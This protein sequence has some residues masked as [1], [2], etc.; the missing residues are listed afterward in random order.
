MAYYKIKNITSTLPKRHHDKDRPVKVEYL[1]GLITK[2]YML[3]AG[4]EIYI[5]CDN[6]P[7]NLRKMRIDK[8]V[9][10]QQIS[11]NV[12]YKLKRGNVDIAK[13]VSAPSPEKKKVVDTKTKNQTTT[14]KKTTTSKKK[15]NSSSTKK[16]EGEYDGIS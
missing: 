16:V 6:L 2:N 10:I 12:Y 15:T 14:A 11:E 7:I 4:E 5:I 13:T 1:D 8:L 3:K 9:S